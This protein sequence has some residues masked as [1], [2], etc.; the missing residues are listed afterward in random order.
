[1][2]IKSL[3][4][5]TPL[6]NHNNTIVALNEQTNQK[7]LLAHTFFKKGDVIAKFSSN[8]V[9]NF[10][11]YLTVQIDE[12]LHITLNPEH[13]QYVNHSCKPN[14]FFDTSTYQLIALEN[15]QVKEELTFFYPS[16]EWQMTQPFACNCGNSN[17]LQQIQ[18]AAF[19]SKLVLS[20]YKL[21]SFIQKMIL[22]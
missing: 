8:L 18:G 9:Q 16:T 15:I 17:C 21:T 3:I 22:K 12:D 20:N 13:L 4:K 5:Y 11:T 14:V 19:I 7:A 2:Q 6:S 1:M 10:P